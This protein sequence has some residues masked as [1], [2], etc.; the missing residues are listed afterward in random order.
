MIQIC[1]L[2]LN[3]NFKYYNYGKKFYLISGHDGYGVVC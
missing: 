3:I 1:G 2:H